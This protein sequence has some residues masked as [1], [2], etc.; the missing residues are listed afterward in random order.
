MIRRTF[1]TIAFSGICAFPILAGCNMTKKQDPTPAAYNLNKPE[2][3]SM[4]ES[5][6]EISGISFYKGRPDSIYSIQDE[7]GK[8]FRMAWQQGKQAHAHFG[9]TGDYEDVSIVKDQVI[10]LKSNGSLFQFPFTSATYPEIDHA[11]EWKHLLP[12]GEYESIYG[13][14]STGLVYVLCKNCDQDNNK[15]VASGFIFQLQG[16][17]LFAQGNFS[18]DVGQIKDIAGKVKRGFR[19]SAL[20]KNPLTGEWF[21]ISAVNKMIVIA[22]SRFTVKEVYPLNGNTFNQPEGIAFD[23]NGDLYISN[24]GSD[25]SSGNILKFKRLTR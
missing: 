9:K 8:L 17:S 2:K 14:D 12:K 10:I 6:L 21:I 4:P 23:K 22:D 20:A 3:F 19:P 7:N 16:D 5:L 11:K 1:I 13:D 18:I 24:E 15:K 25:L